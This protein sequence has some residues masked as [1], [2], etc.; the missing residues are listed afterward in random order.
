MPAGQGTEPGQLGERLDGVA[1]LGRDR[2]HLGAAKGSV[3]PR[4]VAASGAAAADPRPLPPERRVRE[5]LDRP[6]EAGQLHDGRRQ[7]LEDLEAA[8][9]QLELRGNASQLVVE[10]IELLLVKRL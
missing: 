2:D 8:L 5:R 7:A 9:H 3:Y 1:G 10:K 4:Q 6:R